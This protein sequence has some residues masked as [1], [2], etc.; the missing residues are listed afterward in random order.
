MNTWVAFLRAINVAGHATVKMSD[1]RRA[2]EAA[3]CK[4]VRTYIQSG[5]VLFES[6]ARTAAALAR[7][8]EARL[9]GLLGGRAIVV[10]RTAHELQKTAKAAPFKNVRAGADVK[11]YV[12]FLLHAP[13]RKPRLPLVSPK[14]GLE[15]VA[16]KGLE[17]FIVSRKVKRRFGHPNLLIEKE[18][19]VPATTRNWTTVSKMVEL[20]Q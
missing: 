14:E 5:N 15:V 6:P 13:R 10:Y 2:F 8:I 17:A 18:L 20:L 16:M 1:L 4:S 3:G 19:G 11:L 12:A 9:L 7:R